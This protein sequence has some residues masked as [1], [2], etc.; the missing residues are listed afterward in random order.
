MG[1]TVPTVLSL[2][3]GGAASFGAFTPGVERTYTATAPA[4]V[5]STA[6]ER[7]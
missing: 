6:G 3:V 2:S 7:R 1:G 4:V 5:T